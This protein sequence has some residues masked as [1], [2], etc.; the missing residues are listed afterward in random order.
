MK[1]SE[2]INELQLAK[3]K[4]GDVEV[5]MAQ[6]SEE[7]AFATID[8]NIRHSRVYEN[9]KAFVDAYEAGCISGGP[10]K[11]VDDFFAHAKVIGVC[12]RPFAE[13]FR[14]AEEAVNYGLLR[15]V[16]SRTTAE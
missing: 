4:F 1:I 3:D 8:K 6:D 5:I 15:E 7:N 11:A 12:L 13:Y 10:Q 2:M 14:H 9:E 16:E